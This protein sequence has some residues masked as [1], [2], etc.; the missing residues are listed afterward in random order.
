MKSNCAVILAGG[1]GKRMKSSKAKVLCEVLGKPMVDWVMDAVLTA[2]CGDICVVTGHEREQV[3][4]HLASRCETVFQAEQMGTGHAVMQ[5]KDFIARH[6]GSVLVLNGDAPFMDAKTIEDTLRYHTQCNNAVTVISAQVENPYGYGRIVRDQGGYLLKIQEEADAS[7]AEQGIHEVNSGAYWLQISAL[8]PVL[9]ELRPNN[10]LGEYY[11]TDVVELMIAKQMR[12]S[13][14]AAASPH[15]I[16]GANDRVQL[17]RLNEIARHRVL[18]ALM[19]AGVEI[20]CTDGIM[21][22]PNVEVGADT[23]ILPGTILRGNTRIGSNSIIGPN[24]LLVDTTVGNNALLN[25]VQSY[26]SEI[27]DSVNLGPFVHIRPN[28][29][30]GNGVHLGNFVEVKNSTVDELTKVSHLTYVGDSD[31]GKGVNFG[32]GC[33]TV[34]YDGQKKA[35]CTVGD[36][37]FIGCNTNLIAPVTVGEY[38]YTAAGTTVTEDVPKNALAIGRARQVNKDKWVEKNR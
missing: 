20:P 3:E 19:L 4:I 8:L 1:Q 25:S 21:I 14:F 18:E 7:V 17:M 9:E 36:H 2:D 15:V 24:C 27:G 10:A 13:A 35:R 16:L 26:A 5:A 34:N 6:T 37:A 30:I 11:L 22:G 38:A 29:K 28:S 31:V 32:C 33:V 23:Q 12:A